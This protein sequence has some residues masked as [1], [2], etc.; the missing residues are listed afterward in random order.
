MALVL[1][2]SGITAIRMILVNHAGTES[3][4]GSL[5]N[6]NYNPYNVPRVTILLNMYRK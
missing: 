2:P 6:S 3:A 1:K 4:G 5:E